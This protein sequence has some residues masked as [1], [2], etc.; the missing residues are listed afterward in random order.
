MG[1]RPSNVCFEWR[2]SDGRIKRATLD[3]DEFMLELWR[4][5]LPILHPDI[6]GENGEVLVDEEGVVVLNAVLVRALDSIVNKP[7]E[8][9][10]DPEG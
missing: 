7:D 1:M 5:A 9:D 10:E 8:S 3:F 6:N 4:A 2:L